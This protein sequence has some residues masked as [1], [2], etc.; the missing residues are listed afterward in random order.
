MSLPQVTII[1]GGIS[2]ITCGW[3][4][5]QAGYRVKILEKE[6]VLGGL[7]RSF[8]VNDTWIPLT[9]HHVMR[10]DKYT[11]EYIKEFGFSRDLKW[12]KSPQAFWY[13]NQRY[14]LSQP[15]HI[16]KF[17]PLDSRGKRGLFKLGL[18]T[19][20]K[21]NWNNLSD[22]DC[23]EWLNKILGREA[24]ELLFQNLMDIKFSMPL[25]SVSAAW[26]GRRMHQSIRSRDRYGYIKHGWQGL[27]DKMSHLIVGHGGQIL[28]NFEVTRI[29]D[30]EIAGI[31]SDGRKDSFPY[32]IIVST[33][34]PPTLNRLFARKYPHRSAMEKIT[35]KTLVSFVCSSYER[36]S[37]Y[38]WSVVLKP[39]LIFGGFFNFSVLSRPAR[40]S[41]ENILYFFTYRDSNDPFLQHAPDQLKEIYLKDIRKIFPGFRIN[42][43]RIFKMMHSMPVFLRNYKN[44]PIEIADNFYLAGIYR[45]FPK[46]RTMDSAFY[47]GRETAEYIVEKYGKK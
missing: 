39:H 10:P 6:N 45:Q 8:L 35:Y 38:Y 46:P 32:E 16:L 44:P 47:S 19:Y 5:A 7:A 33:V 43:F 40:S 41:R 11:Q 28:N 1:G 15:H 25:S 24:T 29:S 4:L 12:V 30:D 36:I 37:P 21:T 23:D 13:E 2:G 14:L 22:T 18:Y 42:W 27:I 31:D 17:K 3:H 9:Y 26:L 34:P 20:F